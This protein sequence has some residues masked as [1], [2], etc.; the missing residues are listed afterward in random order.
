MTEEQME[1]VFD[2]YGLSSLFSRFK[3]P[4][5]VTGL[6]DEVEEDRLGDFF[7]NIELSS[8]VLF[9]EFRFWFQYFSVAER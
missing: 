7:D 8:D 3:T 5:Y 9:D 4:L 6:L 1:D 2:T